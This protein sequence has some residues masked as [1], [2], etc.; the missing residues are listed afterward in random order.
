M[1][2]LLKKLLVLGLASTVAFASV[3]GIACKDNGDS[4]NTG[5]PTVPNT[6]V[7]EKP[8][9]DISMASSL[10]LILGEEKDA[11]V[12][13]KN[14]KGDVVYSVNNEGKNVVSFENGKV[15]AIGVGSAVIT[16]SFGTA[17]ASCPVTVTYGNYL[18][19]LE[20][21]SN[22]TEGVYLA[23]GSKN[24]IAPYIS[25]NGIAYEDATYSFE[26]DNEEVVSVSSSGVI[27]ANQAT[28]EPVNVT[29]SANWRDFSSSEYATLTKTFA[30]SVRNNVAFLINGDIPVNMTVNTPATF[31]APIE[32]N[33]VIKVVPTVVVNGEEQVLSASNVS[34]VGLGETEKGKDFLWDSAKNNFA[35]FKMGK[36]LVEL[37]YR[38]D[39]DVFTENFEIEITRPTKVLTETVELFSS[40]SGL[41]K[42]DNGNGTYTDAALE[43]VA[44][45]KDV[46]LVDAYSDGVVL[47]INNSNGA[48][49]G[50]VVNQDEETYATITLGTKT[51]LIEVPVKAAAYYMSNAMDVKNALEQIGLYEEIKGYH[52]LLCD[53]DMT[54]VVIDNR[55]DSADDFG[56][57]RYA[58]YR[59]DGAYI[60]ST[61]KKKIG[62]NGVFDGDGY[63]I[64]NGSSVLQSY[65]SA[66]YTKYPYGEGTG[67]EMIRYGNNRAYGFFHNVL[68]QGV[69]KN[70]AFENFGGIYVEGD[71]NTL[72]GLVSPL[73]YS[74]AGTLQNVYVNV[75]EDNPTSRGIVN[76]AGASSAFKNVLVEFNRPADYDFATQIDKFCSN[77]LYAY[78]YGSF[79]NSTPDANAT[80][81]GVYVITPM[82]LGFDT[83]RPFSSADTTA[84]N[85]VTYAENETELKYNFSAFDLV[86]GAVKHTVKSTVGDHTEVE[87]KVLITGKTK[88]FKGIQRYDSYQDLANCTYEKTAERT[89]LFEASEY[90]AVAGNVPIWHTMLDKHSGNYNATIGG[91]NK[92]SIDLYDE[93][94]IDVTLYGASASNVKFTE[95]SDLI[96]ISENNVI[97]GVKIG[98]GA[99]VT[100]EFT[101]GGKAQS[102]KF[103]VDVLYPFY[104]TNNGEMIEDSTFA[105]E[106]EEFEIAVMASGN[107]VTNVRF[108]SDSPDALT[109]NGSKFKGIK[110]KDGI[111]VTANFTYKGDSYVETF[112]LDI[113]DMIAENA[114]LVLDGQD[115]DGEEISLV[116]DATP[117][118]ISLKSEAGSI[119]GISVS[120]ENSNFIASG[121]TLQAS[122]YGEAQISLN[123]TLGGQLH[124][125]RITAKAIH[126]DVVTNITSLVDFDAASGKLFTSEMDDTGV[127]SATVVFGNETMVLT[128]EN[129]GITEGGLI[130]GKTSNGDLVPGVTVINNGLVKF[131][132]AM[133]QMTVATYKKIYTLT[134]QYYTSI[135][136]TPEEL[137]AALDID[138]SM[139]SNN[140]GFFRLNNNLSI[141][142]ASP[143]TYTYNGYSSIGNINSNVGFAGYFDGRGYSIDFN[144]TDV[145]AYGIFGNFNHSGGL[146]LKGP[147]TVKNFAILEYASKYYSNYWM[148]APVLGRF[149]KNHS[150]SG[151]VQFSDIYVSYHA[152][153]LPN[154]LV[155]DSGNWATYDN[156]VIDSTAITG[157][158]TRADARFGD[159]E[160]MISQLDGYNGGVL[161]G[162]MRYVE[163]TLAD[164]INNVVALGEIPLVKGKKGFTLNSAA[165]IITANGDGTYTHTPK[166]TGYTFS[167]ATMPTLDGATEYYYA[168][169][170]NKQDI[171]ILQGVRP[172]LQAVTAFQ[173]NSGAALNTVKYCPECFG[174]F[175]T[176]RTTA[177]TVETCG[178]TLEKIDN[179]WLS[180]VSFDWTFDINEYVNPANT[181]GNGVVVFKGAYKYDTVEEM[182]NSGNKFASFKASPYW[183][184]VDGAL[185]WVGAQA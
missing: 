125:K 114:T 109:I 10:S 160:G 132:D 79:T 80:Y 83:S 71:Q 8:D 165:F 97:K 56:A 81:S 18:P 131:E 15:K 115:V 37:S 101:Y 70:V 14:V 137:R 150:Y 95:N 170:G 64:F 136:E 158:V 120:S 185:V 9:P 161:F 111:V 77:D 107:L 105:P 4:G 2:K 169:P 46:E 154:G 30:V 181:N 13:T 142:S 16:A 148:N 29:V 43:T 67:A 167:Q 108:T 180:P 103:T 90:W 55:I 157:K 51:D 38:L 60:D 42:L 25:Y 53:I 99:E 119:S 40:R 100:A 159:A 145:G 175:A 104:L 32:H 153:A 144:G 1:N 149:A 48:I 128:R 96:E 28:D 171:A 58:G 27:T 76:S 176:G 66:V 84:K 129:G 59:I 78:G 164:K 127:V 20:I 106:G 65:K 147:A 110:Y 173:K 63:T 172:E 24:T 73:S 17:S 126:S 184:V 122:L 34:V 174:T 39:G 163:A 134:A 168:I 152:T 12:K 179:V 41:F 22:I 49:T 91:A 138:Y 21:A 146:T 31:Q 133:I 82:P 118:T 121:S 85:A 26:S 88:V 6:S 93:Q 57:V 130:R 23:L 155:I 3:G 151:A 94:P 33:N 178:A 7:V 87:G 11:G 123:F 35:A 124:V 54:G 98:T 162:Q 141:D 72:Y 139:T 183:D 44:W 74:F 112:T 156:I 52:K 116:I 89:A 36:A 5:S 61:S 68:N 45:G 182:I 140:L 177:C 75:R 19:S 47:S 166:Y 92:L 69:I 62:F 143:L 117:S 135:I 86:H 50:L 102:L 113:L